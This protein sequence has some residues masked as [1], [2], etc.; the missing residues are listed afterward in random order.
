MKTMI[1]DY[2]RAAFQTRNSYFKSHLL[3]ALSSCVAAWA[4]KL[5]VRLLMA[6]C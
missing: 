2:V 5:G 6:S 4:L 3:F 1:L